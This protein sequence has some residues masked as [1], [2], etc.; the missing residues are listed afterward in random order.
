MSLRSK[1]VALAAAAVVAISV[2]PAPALA[3]A[4]D[5]FVTSA[6]ANHW[7]R[8][9]LRAYLNEYTKT[10]DTVPLDSTA[11]GRNY[12]VYAAQFSESEYDRIQPVTY[13]TNVLDRNGNATS[14]YETTDRFYLPSGNYRNDQV[15]YWGSEDISANSAYDAAAQHDIARF[16]PISYWSG[17]SILYSNLR[18][19]SMNTDIHSLGS[20]RGTCVTTRSVDDAAGVAPIMKVDINGV[21]FAAAASAA[22]LAAGDSTAITIDGSSDFGRKTR[23]NLPDYGMYLKMQ[24]TGK[25]QPMKV[26]LEDNVLSVAY[27]DGVQGQYVVVQAYKEDNLEQGATVYAAAGE[28]NPSFESVDINVAPWGLPSLDGYTVKV[29]M[30]DAGK[31]SSLAPATEPV[32]FVGLDGQIEQTEE[33]VVENL[34]V[35]ATADKLQTSWG[36]LSDL[37]ANPTNQKIYFGAKDGQPLQFWIAGRET[38]ATG[39]EI[40]AG[41]S[42]LVLYQAMSVEAQAFNRSRSDYSGTGAVT[43]QLAGGQTATLSGGPATYPTDEI[44]FLLGNVPQDV[45]MLSW[46]HR[47]SIAGAWENGMPTTSGSWQVRCCA[48]GVDSK[49]ET[50]YSAP[51]MLTV[52]KGAPA[53]D[54]F[55]FTAPS[56]LTYDGS[57]KAAT[58]TAK[59]SITG[60]GAVTLTYYE[61]GEKLDGAPTDAGTYTVKIDVAESDSFTAASSLTDETWT[62]TI[63]RAPQ[64][65]PSGVTVTGQQVAGSAD[66]S[67]T[68]V[69]PGPAGAEWRPVGGSWSDVPAGGAIEGLAPSSYEV[70]QKGDANHEASDAV[71]VTVPSFSEAHG[72]LTYPDGTTENAG[73]L[74]VLPASGGTVTFPDGTAVILPGGTVVDPATSAATTPDGTAVAPDGEGG[75]RVTLPDGTE[76]AA[77]SGSTVSEDGRVTDPDGRPAEPP[78]DE[79]PGDQ[80][81]VEDG[82]PA[83]G[84]SPAGEKKPAGDKSDA[85]AETG[86]P[87]ALLAPVTFAAVGAASLLARR[88]VA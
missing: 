10:D 53:V 80:G 67:I 33:G 39:G 35:F 6:Y 64:D 32:T 66:G 88:K 17:G 59:T 77:P 1:L 76:I 8:S 84:K 86:D 18:S 81:S 11:E 63:T 79:K 70:R 34:R 55:D 61:D 12:N 7:G 16:I 19:A 40:S 22:E 87:T 73:G 23:D 52:K 56:D 69:V 65:A 51:V 43:L 58:V 28:I 50:T 2:V 3:E 9:D 78:E 54:D 68:G 24:A 27:S 41:G 47:A 13:S 85:L 62:F 5:T 14:V 49:Y 74:P 31:G 26:R 71:T 15:I 21:N 44:T 82:K 20:L 57:P 30:E 38:A 36:D 75:L 83:D 60:M 46:Q 29:W 48:P 25:F 72:G 42:T 45:S 4:P 37:G